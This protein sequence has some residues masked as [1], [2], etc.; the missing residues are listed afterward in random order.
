MTEQELA[1]R[2]LQLEETRGRAVRDLPRRDGP[3]FREED[4]PVPEEAR[5]LR[6]KTYYQVTTDSE[7]FRMWA[8]EYEAGCGTVRC[9]AG[10]ALHLAGEPARKG[11]AS[12]QVEHRAIRALALSRREYLDGTRGRGLFYVHDTEFVTGRLRELA[13]EA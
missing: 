7:H 3:L 9:A 12:S 8:W 10:W 1:R 5:L 11:E 4:T 13:E 6:K 2:I